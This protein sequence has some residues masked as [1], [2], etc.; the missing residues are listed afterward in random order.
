MLTYTGENT[1]EE[2][3]EADGD[4]G[5][6]VEY[7][8]DEAKDEAERAADKGRAPTMKASEQQIEEQTAQQTEGRSLSPD[9][10]RERGTE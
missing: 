5:A 4:S 8:G 1:E 7:E 2:R 3:S 6:G 10:R 9:R